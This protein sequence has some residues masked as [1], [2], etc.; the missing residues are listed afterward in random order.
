MAKPKTNNVYAIYAIYILFKC[1]HIAFGANLY[2]IQNV[3]QHRAHVIWIAN[4]ESVLDP[5][6]AYVIDESEM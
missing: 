5:I 3:A 6:Q 2:S 1:K 4:V